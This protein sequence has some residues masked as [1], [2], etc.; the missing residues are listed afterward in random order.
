ML[1][2]KKNSSRLNQSLINKENIQNQADLI[3]AGSKSRTRNKDIEER[4]RRTGSGY[5][6]TLS[7][8]KRTTDSKKTLKSMKEPNDMDLINSS[9]QNILA[10]P[11]MLKDH[12]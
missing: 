2:S 4:K 6:T 8:S 11:Q 7:C 1:K 9:R 5:N 12:L 3:A 10:I